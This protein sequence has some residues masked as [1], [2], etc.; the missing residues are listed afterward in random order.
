MARVDLGPGLEGL[1]RSIRA[2]PSFRQLKLMLVWDPMH[3]GAVGLSD[4]HAILFL[5]R[6]TRCDL[7]IAMVDR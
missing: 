1:G 3:G 4:Y 5:S 2:N 6:V 7:S